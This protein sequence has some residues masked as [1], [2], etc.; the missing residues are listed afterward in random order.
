MT[1]LP[2]HPNSNP[3]S[4]HYSKYNHLDVLLSEEEMQRL[5]T[6]LKPLTLLSITSLN[7][8]N[9]FVL[10][11]EDFLKAYSNYIQAL[12]NSKKP[13]FT[14]FR[15]TFHGHWTYSLEGIYRLKQ[16]NR[17]RLYLDS[18][19]LMIKPICI[20]VSE[21]D[22]S[23]HVGPL[24]PQGILWGLRFSFP[25]LYQKAGSHDITQVN[26]KTHSNGQ[27]FKDL[28]AFVRSETLVPSFE[29]NGTLINSTI[30]LGKECF[31]WINQHPDLSELKVC[32]INS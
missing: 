7:E 16:G 28:R 27:L 6:F 17:E 20:Q 29:K 5:F 18:P 30:R 13:P 19:T 10:S 15:S 2:L 22:S 9:P 8:K 32:R 21:V 14:S 4:A 11:K 25:S 24:T 3:P 1:S 23:I 26:P 12:K 31:S